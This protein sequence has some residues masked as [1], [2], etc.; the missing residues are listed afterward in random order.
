MKCRCVIPPF[1]SIPHGVEVLDSI[2]KSQ[3]FRDLIVE[4]AQL[5]RH[6]QAAI[7]SPLEETHAP[8][9]RCSLFAELHG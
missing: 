3:L 2:E 6:T 9:I 1:G 7:V 5:E 8:D 4:I